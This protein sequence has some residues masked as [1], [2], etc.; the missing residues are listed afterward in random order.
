M[1]IKDEETHLL[2]KVLPTFLTAIPRTYLH[3]QKT[4]ILV[5]G[6]G[7]FGLEL[8]HWMVI[9]GATK[10]V[11]TSRSGINSGYQSLMIRRWRKSGV[12]VVIDI[13]DVTTA[14]GAESL[15]NIAKQ[16]GPVGGIFN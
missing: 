14:K 16:I 8:A 3:V 6:L 10:L 1:K 15:I 12:C 4:Y 13:N 9:R 5:G 11:L 7:G 2:Q